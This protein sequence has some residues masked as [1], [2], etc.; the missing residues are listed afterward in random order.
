M[1][2]II[3]AVCI[4]TLALS[5]VA[6]ILSGRKRNDD[7]TVEYIHELEKQLEL[8]KAEVLSANKAA[9]ES[10]QQAMN[11]SFRMLSEHLNALTKAE[12]ENGKQSNE[13]VRAFLNSLK[14]D[15][16][17]RLFEMTENN[18]RK[19]EEIRKTVDER[20][21]ESLENR[22][23]LAFSD[24]NTR[25]TEMQKGFDEVQRLSTQVTKLNGVF[26]NVKNRGTWG[27]VTLENILSEILPSDVYVMQ[28][29]IGGGREA[30]DF[31]V[32]MPGG[33]GEL[34]LPIDAKFPMADYERLAAAYAGG[35]REEVFL[36]RK[37]LLAAIKEQAKS[38]AVKYVN[39]P[40]TTNFAIMYL[41]TEGLFAE[42]A[43]EPGFMD[44]LRANHKIIPCGPT[45]VTALL[46]SLM[47]GFTTLKIQKKSAEVV[48]MMKEFSRDFDKFTDLIE[49]IRK[50][51]EG[52]NSALDG[53]DKRSEIIRKKLV[54]LDL[55]S[56][57]GEELKELT[58]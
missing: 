18:N 35:E 39:P 34:Y 30:V 25:L 45:T 32:R 53:L 10:S 38:I 37:K 9:S 17:K 6:V 19:I 12:Q 2:Y 4:A 40:L 52:I 44:D 47:V 36:A 29:H 14:A 51:S 7:L 31:A 42:V 22:V 20:L 55:S 27:E 50:N 5:V 1:E 23:K 8:V 26:T 43:R 16:E 24:I 41:P 28:Y 54:K 21:A 13:Y 48:R 57:E 11:G 33:E 56:I 49:K 46:N 15:I 58:E 3:L